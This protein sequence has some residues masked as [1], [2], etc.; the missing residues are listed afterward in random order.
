VLSGLP[1]PALIAVFVA[2]GGV[3]WFASK[4]LS[5][6]TDILQDRFHLGQA[7]AGLVLLSI[8]EDLPEVVIVAAGSITGHIGLIIGNLLGG[9]ASQTIMLVGL[10]AFGVPKRPLTYRAGSMVVLLEGVLVVAILSIAVMAT[11]LPGS[12]VVWRITPSD[13]CIGVAWLVG[14]WLIQRAQSGVSWESTV[15]ASADQD[16]RVEQ[17][18]EAH[19][20]AER[21]QA[22][23]HVYVVFLAAAVAILAAGV[24]LEESSSSIAGAIGLPSVI[25]GGTVLAL[26]TAL[27]EFS[28]GYQALKIGD[29]E[30]VVSEVFGSNAFLPVL[31]ILATILTGHA[32]LPYAHHSDIYLTGLG[33]LLT[34]IYM[35][36]MVFRPARQYWRLG[37]DSIVVLGVYVLGVVGLVAV[38]HGG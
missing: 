23:W 17:R 26:V 20:K 33:I 35:W 28:T 3:V 15:D 27:P 34:T 24:G 38:A 19:R 36:G 18:R 2:S 25:F 6:S 5:D 14:T 13:V 8:V 30:L 22:A 1:L 32:V 9:I 29:Y 10:D 4:Y 7:L 21:K 16:P 37:I 12:L 11:Q 31:F